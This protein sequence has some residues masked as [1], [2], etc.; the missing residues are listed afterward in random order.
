MKQA[1]G[2]TL[3][4]LM[5]VVAIVGILAGIGYPQ[6]N[7]YTRKARRAEGINTLMMVVNDQE[8]YYNA[9]NAYKN[10]DATP[11]ENSSIKVN[12][13]K[14]VTAGELWYQVTVVANGSTFTATATA[15]N[16]QTLDKQGNANCSVLTITNTGERQP[17]ICFP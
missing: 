3:V 2:F 8:K 5:I 17:R 13:P 1:D 15:K 12:V 10:G 9:N 4:E 14:G 7:Q 11:L 16:N 6:Y